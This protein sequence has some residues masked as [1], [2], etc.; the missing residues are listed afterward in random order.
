MIRARKKKDSDFSIMRKSTGEII[1]D[2]SPRKKAHT[3]ILIFYR[4]FAKWNLMFGLIGEMDKSNIIVVDA[5]LK[6]KLAKAYNT[7]EKVIQNT[8]NR[9]VKHGF[10]IKLSR[11]KYFISPYYFIKTDLESLE[12]LR[13]M[14]KKLLNEQM[15]KKLEEKQ[16]TNVAA[17]PEQEPELNEYLMYEL[18]S[19]DSFI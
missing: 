16:E 7:S 13:N 9:L 5:N 17:T 10:A 18:E 4:E 3:F 19:D 15:E 6:Y 1:G 2:Y 14:Y 8:F 11:G 12:L